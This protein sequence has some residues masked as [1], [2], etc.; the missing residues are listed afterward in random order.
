MISAIP[1]IA[2]SI[3]CFTAGFF[4][5]LIRSKGW[6]RTITIRKINT[7]LG[8][9]VP[10]ITVVLAGYMG[11]NAGWAIAFFVISLG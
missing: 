10:A 6:L 9:V 7:G 1:F 11:C 8:L 2:Q 5:D 3:V 4:T